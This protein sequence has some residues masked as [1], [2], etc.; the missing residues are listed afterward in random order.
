M[1]WRSPVPVFASILLLTML[2]FAGSTNSVAQV[3]TWV[4]KTN[5]M[6]ADSVAG[7]SEPGRT[8]YICRASYQRGLHPGKLLAG[9]C[10]ITYDGKEIVLAN[11]EVLVGK[12]TW[13]PPAAGLRGAFVA[14]HENNRPL[15]LCRAQFNGQHPGKVVAGSCN[16]GYAGEEKLIK[17][18]EVFYQSPVWVAGKTAPAGAVG[19]QENGQPLYVCRARYQGGLHPGKLLSGSCNIGYGGKEIIVPN[20]EVLIGSGDWGAPR[21]R[22]ANA[23]IAGQ[24]NNSPLYLCR[25][26]YNNGTHPGKVVDGRCNIGF[27]GEEKM[28]NDFEVFYS[29]SGQ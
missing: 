25:G 4:P 23:F 16:I 22:L 1:K 10:N 7:G 3:L 13:G 2:L 21:P 14:G 24:E 18:F 8:L 19:G 11:Y 17:S 9:N 29:R 28:L 6:R 15:Y 20:F 5:S 26:R 27:G 12:G